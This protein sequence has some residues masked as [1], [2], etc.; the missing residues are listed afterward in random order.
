MKGTCGGPMFLM[1]EVGRLVVAMNGWINIGGYE[2][3]MGMGSR[4]RKGY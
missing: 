1:M 3:M 2:V 4:N